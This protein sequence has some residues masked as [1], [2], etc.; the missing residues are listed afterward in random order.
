M[1]S[2]SSLDLTKQ[3][4]G[5]GNPYQAFNQRASS[6]V[7]DEDEVEVEETPVAEVLRAEDLARILLGTSESMELGR[8]LRVTKKLSKL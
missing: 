6:I 4:L 8:R 2:R 7:E 3:D 1:A 5:T